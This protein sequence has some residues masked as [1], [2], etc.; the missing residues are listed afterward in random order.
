MGILSPARQAMRA[1][2]GNM[3]FSRRVRVLSR[4]LAQM[5]PDRASVLDVGAGSGDIAIGILSAKPNLTIEGVDVLVRPDAAIAVREFDGSTLPY[6][7]QTFDYAILVDV[8]HHTD[9]P[10]HLLGE[11]ARVAHHVIVK[12]HYRNGLFA[13]TRLRLMDWVG[14]AHHGV[15]L[16]YNYLS[17][18]EWAS[19]G[20]SCRLHVTKLSEDLHI[21]P[22]PVDWI[23]GRGLHFVA[24][25]SNAK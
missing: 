13:A 20:S 6:P 14:N 12:D 15:R 8:L 2:H 10:A 18:T 5:L 21:Y 19:L 22:P 9:D 4:A 1:V 23:F 3:I 7:D 17:R 11:A 25:L 24:T 16:P